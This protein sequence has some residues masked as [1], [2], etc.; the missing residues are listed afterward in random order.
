MSKINNKSAYPIDNQLSLDDFVIGSDADNLDR[1]RNYLLRGIFSTFK[2]SLGFSSLEFIFSDETDPDLTE[3]DTGYFTTNSNNTLAGAITTIDIN[4]SDINSI[5]ISSFIDTISG[6]ISSFMLVLSKPS[7]SGQIFY[8][9]MT[10]I[11]DNGTH[12]SITVNNFVGGNSL[13]DQ[14]TYSLNFDLAGVPSTLTE[15]DPVFLASDAAAVTA[16]GIANW[17]TAFGWG[18]HAAAGYQAALGGTGIVKSTLGTISYLTD[19]STNWNT[20]FTWGNHAAAGYLT[21]ETDP[22]FTASA[23][24]GVTS[25]RLTQWDTAFG[26]GNHAAVGYITSYIETDPIFSAHPAFLGVTSIR[27]NEWNAAYSWGDHAA[28]GY[29]KADGTVPLTGNWNAGAFTITVDENINITNGFLSARGTGHGYTSV[30][31]NS[32]IANNFLVGGSSVGSTVSLD[33]YLRIRSIANGDLTFQENSLAHTVYHEGNLPSD[34]ISKRAFK[35]TGWATLNLGKWTKIASVSTTAFAARSASFTVVGAGHTDIDGQPYTQTLHIHAKQQLAAGGDPYLQVNTY[36]LNG[37]GFDVGYVITNNNPLPSTVDFYIQGN[38]NYTTWYGFID[39]IDDTTGWTF[40]NNQTLETTPV[41]IVES[42]AKQ[43]WHS[44]NDGTG[45]G[46]DADFLD[47]LQVATVGDWFN[48]IPYTSP[49]GVTE[50]GRYIDF[51]FTDA[52][53]A[54]NDGRLELTSANNW[55]FN[56]NVVGTGFRA[57]SGDLVTENPNNAAATV[58][59]SWLSDVAR[60]RVGGAGAGA[61][62]GFAIQK[63]GDGQLFFVDNTG[64]ARFGATSG[65]GG[66]GS[67]QANNGYF[68]AATFWNVSGA[69]TAAQRADARPDNTDE[70]RLHWYGVNS[71]GGTECFRHAW[72]DG[73]GYMELTYLADVMT[74]D[75]GIQ[76]ITHKITST[77]NVT[78]HLEADTDNVDETH[79]PLFKMTQ[80]GGIIG[81]EMGNI[82]NAG[83]VLTGSASNDSYIRTLRSAENLL[84]GTVST[85]RMTLDM[86]NGNLALANGGLTVGSTADINMGSGAI[87]RSAHVGG[88]LEGSY[89]NVGAN[90]AQTNPIYVIGSSYVPASTTLGNMYGI[91]YAESQATYLNSTDLG[92]TPAGWGMY[93]AA[94]GNARLFFNATSGISYQVGISY[95][96]NFVLNSDER[97]KNSIKDY[98]P[99]KIDIN[100]KSF[101]LNTEKGTPRFGVIAQDIMKTNPEF[102]D[103]SDEGDLSVRYIDLLCAKMAEKDKEIAELKQKHDLLEAKV[104]LLI[105][106]LL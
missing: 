10:G 43:I 44:D 16:L 70:A 51:H 48:V 62:G 12:Y 64:N 78:L 37:T 102:V 88:Y 86:G 4:K 33:T 82:G 59:L 99:N 73:N 18:N 13:V 49:S 105:K 24:A 20:A 92:R 83:T 63:T 47:G 36:H 81:M 52:S 95:A 50:I 31:G 80:D 94:D 56:G 40:Y 8:F 32:S 17:N 7:A 6:N 101:E 106:E 84:F 29:I 45:S 54:D 27:L 61:T 90:A 2:T 87:T 93:M 21:T 100:W 38:T 79:V 9:Q 28:V 55:S 22:V 68:N 77:A 75:A 98:D 57:T 19:N 30:L 41:G 69:D 66:D 96:S 5:D 42:T 71:T 72:Y 89:N 104:E 25:L 91:G 34:E 103:S 35:T 3:T 65:N 39:S 15:L 1:T 46:L 26:W 58:S 60:L 74:W 23:A 85:I 11:V 14:T 76:N 53:V 67:V 97:R